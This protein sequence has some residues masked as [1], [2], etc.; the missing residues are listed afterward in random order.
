MALKGGTVLFDD[1]FLKSKKN[2]IKEIL[3][4]PTTTIETIS[5]SKTR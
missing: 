2:T 4:D 3:N 1:K 5:T